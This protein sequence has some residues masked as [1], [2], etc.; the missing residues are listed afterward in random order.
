[1]TTVRDAFP[2]L[3]HRWNAGESVSQGFFGRLVD[4]IE[5]VMAGFSAWR[6]ERQTIRAIAHLDAH[7]LHDILGANLPQPLPQE[8]MVR[9]AFGRPV[10]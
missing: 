4:E 8:N 5:Q 1:M 9:D 10:L 2:V 6:G 3:A 7:M